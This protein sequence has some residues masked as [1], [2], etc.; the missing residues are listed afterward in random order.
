MCQTSYV[1]PGRFL[2]GRHTLFFLLQAPLVLLEKQLLGRCSS[3]A[4]GQA[5]PLCRHAPQAEGVMCKESSTGTACAASKCMQ[6]ASVGG[7]PSANLTRHRSSRSSN[8]SSQVDRGVEQ[9]T[10]SNSLACSLQLLCRSAVTF[11]V[12]FVLAEW[13]FWP[14]LEACNADVN[15][16][17]EISDGLQWMKQTTFPSWL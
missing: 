6:S 7:N 2:L 9:V 17:A 15:G 10:A 1:Q 11:T 8:D 4:D 14:P 16:I 3:G 12:L 13:L 5:A